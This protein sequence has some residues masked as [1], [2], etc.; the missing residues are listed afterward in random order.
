MKIGKEHRNPFLNIKNDHIN[1]GLFGD[2]RNKTEL[3]FRFVY[4]DFYEY[5]YRDFTTNFNDVDLTKIVEVNNEIFKL[6]VIDSTFVKKI[7]KSYYSA[8]SG[9][10]FVFNFNIISSPDDDYLVKID[11]TYNEASNA[12]KVK[13]I[14]VFYF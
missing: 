7:D 1:I 14:A 9:I 12:V 5:F 11:D 6:S 2:I 10:I 3:A 13:L 8:V 4:G